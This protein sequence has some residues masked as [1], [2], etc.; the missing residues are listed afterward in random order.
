[1]SPSSSL[2]L[3]LPSPSP[4]IPLSFSNSVPP[5]SPPTAHPTDSMSGIGGGS[6]TASPPRPFVLIPQWE[7][8]G[9]STGWGGKKSDTEHVNRCR[10]SA[11]F[12]PV[13]H[14][15]PSM[16]G[17]APQM[18][19]LVTL[20]DLLNLHTRVQPHVAAVYCN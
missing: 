13:S 6:K 20:Y 5:S 11:D 18:A 8:E 4:P 2:F 14:Y 17:S 3:L 19:T 15:Y 1:M 7:C 10:I 12:N 9:A 16:R